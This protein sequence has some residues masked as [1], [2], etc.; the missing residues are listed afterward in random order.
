MPAGEAFQGYRLATQIVLDKTGTLT[1]GRPSLR[2]NV[3]SSASENELLAVAAESAAEHPLART[4]VEAAFERGITPPSVDPFEAV[5]GK[6]V[7]VRIGEMET[8]VGSPRFLAERGVAF[9]ALSPRLEASESEGHTVIA[10]ARGGRSLGLLALGD[11]LRADAV[12]T[13]AALR[14]AGLNPVLV[15]GDNERAARTIAAKLG[16]ETV[17]AGVLPGGKAEIVRQLQAR[18]RVAMVGDGINDAPALMQADVGMA[19][20]S[21]TDIAIDSADIIVLGSRLTALVEAG[22]ISRRSYRTMLRNVMLAFL[23]NGVRVPLAATGLVFPVW[24]MAAMATSVTVIFF[25]SLWG[26]PS[27]FFDAILSVGRPTQS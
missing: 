19:M 16:I 17:H 21:G 26:R 6:S 3:T 4:V 24:A 22:N 13:V 14:E 2:E 18:S 9:D 7:V 25:N 12:Q 20:G 27:L 15:T 10:V 23:F 5:P 11:N 1:E 8:L